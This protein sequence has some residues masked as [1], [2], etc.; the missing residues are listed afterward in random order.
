MNRVPIP[1]H[2]LWFAD[3]DGHIYQA[4]GR[5]VCEHRKEAGEERLRVS[6]FRH[7]YHDVAKLIA[8]AF[9]GAC[10]LQLHVVHANGNTGD[11][12]RINLK[13]VAAS[14]SFAHRAGSR[15]LTRTEKEQVHQMLHLGY[16][17]T[18]IGVALRI[19]P[20]CVRY[21][22]TSCRCPEAALYGMPF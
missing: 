7:G 2:P 22:A 8:T 6:C 14:G 9:F 1:E 12:R 21:H 4:D 13:L 20:R 17:K 3:Q 11:I 15:R 19:S 16:P 10:A 5:P 18:A